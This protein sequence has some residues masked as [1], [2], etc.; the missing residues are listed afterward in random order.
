[1]GKEQANGKPLAFALSGNNL[2]QMQ[3]K[4]MPGTMVFSN[5]ESIVQAA[6]NGL[7]PQEW[8]KGLIE[9]NNLSKNPVIVPEGAVKAWQEQQQGL[10]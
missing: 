4:L 3:E 5:K 10:K 7:I 1:M 6:K 9:V 2:G 8:E